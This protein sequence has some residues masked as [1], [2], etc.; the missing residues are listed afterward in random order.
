MNMMKMVKMKAMESPALF[1]VS[2][3]WPK[4]WD[5]VPKRVL[6]LST[7]V[8]D[9]LLAMVN[10]KLRGLAA[11]KG[12]DY[13]AWVNIHGAVSAVLPGDHRLGLYPAEFE[14]VEFHAAPLVGQE[15][16]KGSSQAEGSTSQYGPAVE[17]P[18]EES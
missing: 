5:R 3:H 10:P 6:M 17:E 8:P 13:L 7:A 4:K 18:G 9:H 15:E 14:V 2:A 11:V 16:I 12:Q 1:G